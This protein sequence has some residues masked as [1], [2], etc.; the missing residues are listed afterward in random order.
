MKIHIFVIIVKNYNEECLKK[1]NK[2]S[3]EQKKDLS[4][5]QNAE[6]VYQLKNRIK[7]QIII[8]NK[9]VVNLKDRII[10]DNNI[11]ISNLNRQFLFRK[12]NVSKSKL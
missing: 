8:I 9:F 2:K 12:D 5:I 3:K 11:E 6:M 1:W 7:N 10:K 4:F